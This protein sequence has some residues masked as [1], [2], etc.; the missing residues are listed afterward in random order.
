MTPAL[1]DKHRRALDL[2]RRGNPHPR[3]CEATRCFLLD[4]GYIVRD[5][6]RP[7]RRGWMEAYALG[8]RAGTGEGR[9][10]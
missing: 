3:M 8:P 5:G 2:I 4:E 7:T 10:G 6:A 1:N 9:D